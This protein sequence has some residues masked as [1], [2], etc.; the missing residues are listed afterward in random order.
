[1]TDRQPNRS[2]DR[3]WPKIWLMTDPRFGDDLLPAIRRLPR[4]S[5]V[6]FRHNALEEQ[7]R[8][9]LFRKIL[10]ICRQRG[11][12]LLL[13]APELQALR[14]GADGFHSR[15]AKAGA[16]LPRSAPV[17]DRAELREALRK[18]AE[19]IFLSPLFAT[20]SHPGGKPLGRTAFNA[21]ARQAEPQAVIALGGMTRNKARGIRVHGWA[22]IDAFR[23][24]R[25]RPP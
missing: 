1:M 4:G 13:S 23:K 3:R 21:L 8:L 2:R 7:P 22:A 25:I 12:M 19:L 20:A 18:R 14:W 15:G 11:H 9:R 16:R 24:D 5:G 17:H 6:V 10:R